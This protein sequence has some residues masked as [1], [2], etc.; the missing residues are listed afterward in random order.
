MHWPLPSLESPWLGVNMGKQG[1]SVEQ[2]DPQVSPDL[3]VSLLTC[4][5]NF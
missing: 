5:G 4:M 2:E 3:K 1:G